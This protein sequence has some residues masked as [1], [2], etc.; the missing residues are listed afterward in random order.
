MLLFLKVENLLAFWFRVHHD[1]FE[2]YTSK[3]QSVADSHFVTRDHKIIADIASMLD[4][5]P[6]FISRVKFLQSEIF[7]S[8]FVVDPEVI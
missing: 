3:F 7:K 4:N 1:N 6:A 2:S 8:A 5:L